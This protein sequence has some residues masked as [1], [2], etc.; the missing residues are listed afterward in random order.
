M[1]PGITV[2]AISTAVSSLALVAVV[3]SLGL[4]RHQTHVEAESAIRQRHFDLLAMT[5]E[6]PGLRACWGGRT[7]PDL[8]P[9]QTTFCNMIMSH[10]YTAWNTGSMTEHALRLALSHFFTGDVGFR[11]WSMVGDTWVMDPGRRPRR[12]SAIATDVYRQV[13]SIKVTEGPA[14]GGDN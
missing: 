4:Q 8:M 9:E 6:H 5:L 14:P 13:G 12:F 1:D 11:Y 3:V 7:L 10:W 2:A